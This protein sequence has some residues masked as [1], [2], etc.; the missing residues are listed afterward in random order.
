[1]HVMFTS[2][3]KLEGLMDV[4]A[5]RVFVFSVNKL[6]GLM[7]VNAHGVYVSVNKLDGL[8]DVV[9]HHVY[10]SLLYVYLT[11]PASKQGRLLF[12]ALPFSSSSSA[13][14]WAFKIKSPSVYLSYLS[15]F[16]SLGIKN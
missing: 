11:N 3:N 8:M 10:V 13:V 6:E 4:K 1:M 2:V 7:D 9:A 14:D 5:R 12:A 16:L 15:L